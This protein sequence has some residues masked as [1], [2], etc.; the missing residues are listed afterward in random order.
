MGFVVSTGIVTTYR[1]TFSPRSSQDPNTSNR[2]AVMIDLI[3]SSFVGPGTWDGVGRDSCAGGLL[4]S[5]SRLHISSA[6]PIATGIMARSCCIFS[7]ER[8]HNSQPTENVASFQ[9]LKPISIRAF[10]FPLA[11]NPHCSK[12]SDS[13][14]KGLFDTAALLLL[15]GLRPA[16]PLFLPHAL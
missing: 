6:V 2:T 16:I 8:S 3:Y 15:A 9:R 13:E 4:R 7:N 14:R 12:G 5:C 1:W 10:T 11:R